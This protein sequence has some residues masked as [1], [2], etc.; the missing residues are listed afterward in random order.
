M[1]SEA[2][3][4]RSVFKSGVV[5]FLGFVMESLIAFGAK[6]VVARYLKR[7]DFGSVSIG[8][9]SLTLL[10]GFVLLGMKEGVVRHVPRADT[11]T[12]RRGFLIS[13]Y[14]VVLISVGVTSAILYFLAEPV[15]VAAF[16]DEELAD[17]FKVVAFGVPFSALLTISL[18]AVQAEGVTA[19]KVIVQNFV[20]PITRFGLIILGVWLGVQ[21]AGI[22]SA[23]A[24][25]YLVGLM[26]V[27][28]FVH[29]Q[30][31]L[32][33]RVPYENKHMKL[34]TFSLPLMFSSLLSQVL[35]RSDTILI[36][37]FQSSASAGDYDIAYTLARLMFMVLI[38]F[39]YLFLPIF[40]EYHS[41][42]KL[43]QARSFY[44]TITKWIFLGTLPLFFGMFLFPEFVIDFAFGGEYVA[45]ATALQI[46][47]LGFVFHALVGPNTG[48]LTAFGYTK[49]IMATDIAATGS[50]LLINLALIPRFGIEGAAF[51]TLFAYTV[52]NLTQIGWL[53]WKHDLSPFSTGLLK[54]AAVSTVLMG[55]LYV[56]FNSVFE[57]SVVPLLGLLAVSGLLYPVVIVAFGGVGEDELTI[58]DSVEDRFDLNLDTARRFAERLR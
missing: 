3:G 27:L 20:M 5:I 25:T 34:L 39:E 50:N 37:A 38:S 32:F 42:G 24:I 35:A 54:P 15:A 56:A 8:I 33:E 10:S 30:T 36:G 41:D 22:M 13:A 14:Q 28:Y 51:A 43:T 53:Y 17:I 57:P 26:V 19:P 23:Y 46:V 4:V 40:S 11:K 45:G 1:T 55:L 2:D 12:E 9:A 31:P 21:A 16:G 58:I 6:A 18:G 7:A 29:R 48:A 47:A 52:R 44:K 49:F